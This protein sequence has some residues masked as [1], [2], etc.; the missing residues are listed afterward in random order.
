MHG[1]GV[2]SREIVRTMADAPPTHVLV[3]AG[4]GALAASVCAAFWLAWGAR[5]PQLVIVEPIEA[6]CLLPERARRPTGRGH[7]R[8]RHGDGR[9]RLRRSV[10]ARV[11][12]RRCRR[13]RVRHRRRSLCAR[14]GA[15]ARLGRPPAIRPSWPA[16]PA[17]ADSRRCWPSRIT[18]DLRQAPRA[19]R[20]IAGVADRQ[21]RR[22]RSG[23]LSANRRAT[24][25]SVSHALVRG[26]VE[27]RSMTIRDLRIDAARL[28]HASSGWPRSARSTAAGA[29]AS[30]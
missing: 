20:G 22:H 2:M 5:R 4:V 8:S 26:M 30:R 23:D 17:R 28:C 3:Q 1:Y 24:S 6:D 15:R 7:R 25:G 11:G 9:T 14:R 18:T 19:R 27:N 16:K 29:A 13:Q 12:D 21:R 10:A